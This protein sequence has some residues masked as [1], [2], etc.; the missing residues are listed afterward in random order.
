MKPLKLPS[1]VFIAPQ[2]DLEGAGLV[3]NTQEPFYVGRIIKLQGDFGLLYW[4]QEHSPLFFAV[5]T[6]YNIVI[7]Y[8]GMLKGPFVRVHA[9]DYKKEL[10]EVVDRMADWYR[11][12]KILNNPGYYK[13]Y[14]L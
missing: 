13:R 10:Q 6:P 12:E 7:S 2:S 8:A 3:L 11:K 14:L 5:C 9:A 4:Q 1:H